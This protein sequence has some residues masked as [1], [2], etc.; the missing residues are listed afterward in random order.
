MTIKEVADR[1]GVTGETLRYYERVGMLPPVTRTAGGI[2]D[3]TAEDLKWV[4]LVLCM[5]KAGLPLEAIIEYVRLYREGDGTFA[6][7]LALL[8][9]QR[10][11][12]LDR[13]RTID[14]TL[15]RLDVKIR[16]YEE[17]V[18]TGKLCWDKDGCGA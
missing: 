9:E 16:R 11:V 4:E 17:A 15:K 3:Y 14:E 2:R 10:Q 12:L 7:R 1:C 8:R 13:K 18:R 5:R 6:A